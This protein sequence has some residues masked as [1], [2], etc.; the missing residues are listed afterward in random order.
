MSSNP[1]ALSPNAKQ[2]IK[3]AL[4]MVITYGLALQFA[5]MSSTWPAIAV[6]F[7][8]QPG[9]GQALYKGLMRALGTFVAFFS[10][11]FL[12]SL[13]PQDRWMLLIATSPFM[14]Y[15]AYKM[16]GENEYLWF[17]AG[18][19][20]PMI[21]MA[22]PSDP[23]HAFEF[24]A[25][26]TLETL[27]GI[28]VWALVSAFLWPVTNLATL[29]SATDDLLA[30]H[31]QLL[32]SYRKVAIGEGSDGSASALQSKQ[33]QLVTKVGSL[34]DVV[35]AETYEVRAVRRSWKRLH[36]TNLSFMQ[37]AARLQSGVQDVRPIDRKAVLQGLP[38][39]F[40]ELDAR[41]GEARRLLT[42]EAP[43][44]PSQPVSLVVDKQALAALDHF[45]RAAVEVPRREL[46]ALGVQTGTMLEC[47]Q[48]IGGVQQAERVGPGAVDDKEPRGAFG[49]PP[50]DHDQLQAG[51]ITVISMWVGAL[52][53][54]Y[55]DPPGHVSWF[56]FIPNLTLAALRTPH[57]RFFPLKMFAYSYVVGMVVY[58][59]LMPHLSGFAELGTLIFAFSFL[60]VYFFPK[61]SAI[62][63]MAMFNMFGISNQQTYDFASMIN[64]Y[65]F[66]MAGIAVVYALTYL[67][68]SP[69][70]EKT[71]LKQTRRFFRS[72]QHLVSQEARPKTFMQ[73]AAWAYHLQELR[74]L[75]GKM[76]IWGKQINPQSFPENSAEQV[77]NL[78]AGLQLLAY[79][80][81]DLL[82]V[83]SE[84][85]AELLVRELADDMRAWRLV[86][87]RAFQ[88]WS[89]VPEADP[90]TDLHQRVSERLAKINARIEE[91]SKRARPDEVGAAE[92][93]SFYRLLGAFRNLTQAGAGYADQA[94]HIDW[95]DWREE[96]FE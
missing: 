7:I 66:T 48:E 21:I 6:A 25:Y 57:V 95:A 71:F 90:G 67:I 47:L 65:L 20:T 44:R 31:Q 4:A 77:T 75:P 10:S 83:R 96:R 62:L 81:E 19:V 88:Q 54:I 32:E 5:W 53:W 72:C 30:T 74:S 92:T 38:E 41:L 13:F 76:A 73:Q 87:E 78:V 80:I 40:V 68:G 15:F 9:E 37:T 55:V 14:G 1:S 17:V 89:A 3:V 82:E 29:K 86:V 28:G 39:L 93:R 35:A 49:L 60:T 64:S 23:G 36:D 27:V 50:L 63:F 85:Q 61:L 42:G 26:R 56:Q 70:P 45:E 22:G 34:I 33:A 11:L 2:G 84:R 8:A 16:R 51:I 69:R 18:F 46:E 59:F 91:L 79:R 24:A 52:I 58:V 12:L 94:R 43:G